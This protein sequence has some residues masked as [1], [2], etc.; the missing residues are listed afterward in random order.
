MV[1]VALADCH[2][3]DDPGLQ[4]PSEVRQVELNLSVDT[5]FL[6]PLDVLESDLLNRGRHVD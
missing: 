6:H 5:L 3:E 1:R 2:F 4:L